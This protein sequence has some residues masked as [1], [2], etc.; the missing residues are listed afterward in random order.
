MSATYFW[1]FYKISH[2]ASYLINLLILTFSS[3]KI[4][5]QSPCEELFV[6]KFVCNLKLDSKAG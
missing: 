2:H 5:Q 1:T 6:Q 4:A 3:L